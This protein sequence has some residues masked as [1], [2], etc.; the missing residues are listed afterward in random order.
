MKNRVGD[1]A[2]CYAKGVTIAKMLPSSG[3]WCVPCNRKRL[4][5]DK[6]ATNKVTAGCGR[7]KPDASIIK[8]LVKELDTVFSIFIRTRYADENGLVSCCTCPTRRHWKN[9]HCGH[10]Y[11]RASFAIRWNVNNAHVQC[12]ECN[13]LGNGRFD[14]HLEYARKLHGDG[15]IVILASI[16][17]NV[18]N[19]SRLELNEQI[20]NFINLNKQNQ[21]N[22][23]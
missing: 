13:L 23:Y 22:G 8:K 2:Q 19:L 11:S 14:D 16:K 5:K 17:N 9:M 6:P 7:F 21:Q 4:D 18:T 3:A 10:L 20:A 15:T 1:C 12:P